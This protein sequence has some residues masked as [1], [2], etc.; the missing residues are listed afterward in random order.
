[1]LTRLMI[2]EA[3]TIRLFG[4]V[5][6][7]VEFSSVVGRGKIGRP[8]GAALSHTIGPFVCF[9]SGSFECCRALEESERDERGELK[10]MTTSTHPSRSKCPVSLHR[11]MRLWDQTKSTAIPRYVQPNHTRR[12]PGIAY[13]LLFQMCHNTSSTALLPI[14]VSTVWV[15]ARSRQIAQLAHT[16]IMP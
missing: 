2:F 14:S 3:K 11:P 6:I 7:M 12:A 13:I 16:R 15:W 10:D 1:M 9:L 4:P 5:A 8:G